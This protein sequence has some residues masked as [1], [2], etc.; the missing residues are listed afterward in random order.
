MRGTFT[1]VEGWS[2]VD[3]CGGFL[4]ILLKKSKAVSSSS[5]ISLARMTGGR[6]RIGVGHALVFEPKEVKAK[7]VPFD[8]LGVIVA[9]HRIFLSRIAALPVAAN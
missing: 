9:A 2:Q 6:E 4:A 5:A 1:G 3:D 7:L 8:Q